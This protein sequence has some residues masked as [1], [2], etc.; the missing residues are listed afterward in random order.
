MKCLN[1]YQ[2]EKIITDEKGLKILLWKKHLKNCSSC[3]A[4]LKEINDNI[5]FSKSVKWMHRGEQ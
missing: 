5:D 3:L 4:R 2:L 1:E